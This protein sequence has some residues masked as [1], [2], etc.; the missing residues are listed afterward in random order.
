MMKR[1]GVSL[2]PLPMTVAGAVAGLCLGLSA[3]A[4]HYAKGTSYLGNDP[5]SC[6]NCH[7]MTAQYDG[8]LAG[9]HHH[10]ATCNDCHTPAALVPK[11]LVKAENGLHHSLAF[12]LGGY[13]DVIRARPQSSAIVEANCRRCHQDLVDEIARGEDFH[14]VRCHRSVGHPR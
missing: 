11:Y 5:A 6:A 13:P 3:Y 8:W 7:V 1:H 9:P 12:T 10:V 2:L 14:C 4:F